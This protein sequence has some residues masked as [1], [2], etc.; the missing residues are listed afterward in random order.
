MEFNAGNEETKL[1]D[2]YQLEGDYDRWRLSVF[3]THLLLAGA[4]FSHIYTIYGFLIH[5]ITIYD[6]APLKD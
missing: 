1:I 6:Y 3:Q 4:T 5:K 2:T